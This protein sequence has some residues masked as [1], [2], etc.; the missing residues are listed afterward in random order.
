MPNKEGDL[1]EGEAREM[2]LATFRKHFGVKNVD[3]INV[4][5]SKF[6]KKGL[7]DLMILIKDHMPYWIEIKRNFHDTPEKLQK[8]RVKQ[9]SRMG[10]ITGF[11]DGRFIK[12]NWSDDIKHEID[13]FIKITKR[14]CNGKA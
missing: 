6:M 12:F 11:S 7:P 8:F 3:F 5:G 13:N 14:S 2:I 4:H 10:F 1:L 9:Y